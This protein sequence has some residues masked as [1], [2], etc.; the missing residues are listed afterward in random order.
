M[1]SET[2]AHNDERKSAM[3]IPHR[4]IG[5]G[6]HKVLVLHDWFGT[7]T[8]WGPFLD[9][10]DGDTFSYAFLDYRGYGDRK[11]VTGTYT[12]AEIAEDALALADELILGSIG[13]DVVIGAEHWLGH[14]PRLKTTG[15]HR[16]GEKRMSRR[17]GQV[18]LTVL[19]SPEPAP[20][21]ASAQSPAAAISQSRGSIVR[22]LL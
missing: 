3:S 13:V 19:A 9:Y 20:A 8:G 2:L 21:P 6:D 12:L 4:L 10:L 22:N 11:H 15:S 18:T 7:S 1:G 16:G 5:L 17:A 14:A